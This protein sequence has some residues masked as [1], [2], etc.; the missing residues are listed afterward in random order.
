MLKSFT[1]TVCSALF[2]VAAFN[3]ASQ[4]GFF[5][6][7]RGDF[8][9][10]YV[11]RLRS[12][13]ALVW[14]PEDRA[15]KY[16]LLLNSTADCFVMGSSQTMQIARVNFAPARVCS[17]LENASVSGASL[18]DFVTAARVIC[19]R[20][21]RIVF[22]GVSPWWFRLNADTR[23]TELTTEY[24][25][26]RKYFGLHVASDEH[27]QW[28]DVLSGY[29]FVHGAVALLR[30]PSDIVDAAKKRSTDGVI[31]PDGQYIYPDSY[32]EARSRKVIGRGLYG[33]GEPLIEADAVYIFETVI[34]AFKRRGV[35][36]VLL[37]IPYHPAVWVNSGRA[38]AAMRNAREVVKNI[39]AR[40]ELTII[41]DFDPRTLG[42]E[43]DDFLDDIHIAEGGLARIRWNAK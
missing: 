2:V 16:E 39:A 10:E 31:R 3:L 32:R 22:I 38:V 29:R 9:K 13:R 8:I 34:D 17:R 43:A 5:Q 11:E 37:M 42:L 28:E 24:R 21:P 36:P 4:R 1:I 27:P 14:I 40:R 23:W 12:G 30:R 18:E 25:Q 20:A 35:T 7:A 15:I 26:A 33:I 6:A 41:G 19:E